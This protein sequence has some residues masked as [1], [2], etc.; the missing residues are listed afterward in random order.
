MAKLD[1]R[2][3]ERSGSAARSRSTASASARCASPARASGASPPTATRRSATLRRLPELGV[4][5]IDTADSYGPDVSEDLIREALHP[6]ERHRRRH[7]GRASRGTAR[8][9]G[10]RSGGPSTC[11]SRRLMSLRRLGVERID[12]WQLHRIDRKVPRD[13]Q[14]G[15][16]AALHRRRADPPRRAERGVASRRSRRRGRSSRSR[17]CRTATTWS[18]AAARTCSTTASSRASASSRGIRSP[19]ASSRTSRLAARHD[20]QA[21]RRH[22]EPGRAG[23]G[24]EA[25][26]GDAADPRHLARS[27]ISRRTSRRRSSS[28]PTRSSPELDR[29]G[30]A[31]SEAA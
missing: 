8:T 22:A 12:L 9:S 4:D 3:R 18:I 25:Q 14:F 5:F 10:C 2:N 15:V 20:R 19:P 13:E 26:P 30:R 24:A 23:L 16:I 29:A 17:P 28:S 1:A 31:A 27:R 11:A 6:Y 21:P 7:Q